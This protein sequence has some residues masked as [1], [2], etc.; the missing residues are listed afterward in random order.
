MHYYTKNLSF[1]DAVVM[2]I[3]KFN[4]IILENMNEFFLLIVNALFVSLMLLADILVEIF[5][6][7]WTIF[8]V[9]WTIL[10]VILAKLAFSL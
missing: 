9:S 6:D 4:S 5:V 10:W 7:F 8:A 3:E 1:I 2:N